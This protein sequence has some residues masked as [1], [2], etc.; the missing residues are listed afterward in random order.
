MTHCQ[1][2]GRRCQQQQQ[3]QICKPTITGN[4]ILMNTNP[5]LII[6]T[7]GNMTR[8]LLKRANLKKL[9][10]KYEQWK[11]FYMFMKHNYGGI[12]QDIFKNFIYYYI[13][14]DV[15]VPSCY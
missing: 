4:I 5:L 15:N 6:N 1:R 2:R 12:G 11:Q 14:M 8:K 3:Q 9:Y 7:D 10:Y 13:H